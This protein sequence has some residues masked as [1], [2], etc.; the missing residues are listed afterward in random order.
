MID[1]GETKSADV[2]AS[3]KTINDELKAARNELA[4]IKAQTSGDIS[5]S[6][7]SIKP[8]LKKSDDV[9]RGQMSLFDTVTDEEII[10]EIRELDCNNLTPMEAL[11]TLSKL[12]NKL[13]NRWSSR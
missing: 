1:N 13:I 6:E 10:R 12:Q 5:A 9:D 4:Q 2:R 11:N 7:K 3:L 8:I